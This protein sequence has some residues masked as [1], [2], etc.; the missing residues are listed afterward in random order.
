MTTIPANRVVF[1]LFGYLT[2]RKGTLK[3]LEALRLLP[4][5]IASQIG[6]LLVGKVA[7]SISDTVRRQLLRL[8]TERPE[9]FCHLEDRRVTSEE[10][11]AV[12]RRSDVVLA[13]YQRFVGSSGVMLWA[14]R[15]GK[16]LL[17]QDF[18]VLNSFMRD[19]HLGLTVDC[20]KPFLLADAIAQFVRRGPES[21]IDLE[22]ARE[23][24]AGRS[25]RRFAEIVLTQAAA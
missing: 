10:I 4:R 14:A 2:E 3:L 17:T 12:V 22:A 24:M 16:P 7:S 20:T 8:E 1:L 18:G 19:Y 9:I 5:E 6:V 15:C 25:P 13:P 21:F 11:E 23:F